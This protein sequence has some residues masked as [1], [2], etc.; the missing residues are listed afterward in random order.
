LVEKIRQRVLPETF[1]V[2]ELQNGQIGIHEL[3]AGLVMN[4]GGLELGVVDA[5]LGDLDALAE[6][7][8]LIQKIEYHEGREIQRTCT[9]TGLISTAVDR[10]FAETE[11]SPDLQTRYVPKTAF[12]MMWMA[13][14]KPE[15]DDVCN[16]IKEVCRGFEIEAVRADD[17]EHQD[18]I[19]D[20]VLER[21]RTSEF[22]IADV[23][24]ERPNVYYEIGYAHA[25][26][27]HPILYRKAG[28]AL[29][30]DISVHNA[31]E[32][33]NLMHLRELLTGRLEALLG[34]S[35]KHGQGPSAD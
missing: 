7:R 23:T 26:G 5:S 20:V 35:A 34:R 18:K 25:A 19:T 3:K 12:I 4:A 22:L 16:A 27:K 14:D 6:A 1:N 9:V 30:F 10:N 28:T 32:Y 29:H 11:S 13:S 21:I 15:L 24:G 33:R 2:F 8:M 31:P 17:I